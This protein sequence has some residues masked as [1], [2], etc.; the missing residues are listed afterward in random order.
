MCSGFPVINDGTWNYLDHNFSPLV[1]DF[2]GVLVLSLHCIRMARAA[3]VASGKKTVA[4]S[5]EDEVPKIGTCVA[6]LV[7]FSYAILIMV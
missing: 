3:K 6:I 2:V 5:H 7:Y 4:D 1:V